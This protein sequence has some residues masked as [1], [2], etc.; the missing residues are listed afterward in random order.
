MRCRW[1]VVGSFFP[2][3]GGG[4]GVFSGRA[5]GRQGG[6]RRFV[7]RTRSP[8][9]PKQ[10]PKRTSLS[11]SAHLFR[12]TVGRDQLERLHLPK[13][14]RVT[15][16]VDVHELGHVAVAV[17]VRERVPE[18]AAQRGRL[19][20]DHGAL[21]GGRLGLAHGPDEVAEADGAGPDRDA[22]L[23]GDLAHELARHG[24]GGASRASRG[25][26]HTHTRT[27][28][29]LGGR[30]RGG[31]SCSRAL[32]LRAPAQTRA[33]ARGGERLQ[34]S[35]SSLTRAFGK[36]GGRKTRRSEGSASLVVSV[37]VR[38]CAFRRGNEL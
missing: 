12:E 22:Q 37:V 13:V 21:L 1:V 36:G 23:L 25:H 17:Q 32:V 3:F 2:G 30:E 9:P 4:V 19:F 28:G 14:R 16:H 24:G 8:P 27:S 26:Q 33:S 18:G 20:R 29:W 35:R 5:R 7:R 11:L 34:Q 10:Q 15:K 31:F 38:A 6:R